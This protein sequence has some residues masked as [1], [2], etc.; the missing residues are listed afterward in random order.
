MFISRY[1]NSNVSAKLREEGTTRNYNNLF[2]YN[3]HFNVVQ[4]VFFPPPPDNYL[5]TKYVPLFQLYKFFNNTPGF[6]D[7]EI[8]GFV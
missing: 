8:L 5:F 4:T 1:V 7:V 6:E 2:R 3:S